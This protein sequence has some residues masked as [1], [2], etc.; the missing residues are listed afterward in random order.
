M[1][2]HTIV[3][4]GASRGIGNHAAVQMLRQAPD[5]H[6]PVTARGS[7]ED[8]AAQL[9]RDSGNPNVSWVTCELS[10]LSSIRSA[11]AEIGR[12]LETGALPPLTGF[13]GNAGVQMASANRTTPDD[14]ETTFAVN[15]LANHLF[16]RLLGDRLVQPARVVITTSDTHFGD[17][18]HNMGMVPAPQ[19]RAPRQLA[20]AGSSAATDTVT[21]GR[22]TYSTSKLAVIH[23]VHEF[24]RQLPAGVDIYSWNPGF[25]PGTGLAR[26]ANAVHRFAMRYVMPLMALTPLSVSA[27][28]A[29]R[30]LADV[31]LGDRLAD[32]G[33]YINLDEPESSSTES[34]DPARERELWQA[35]DELCRLT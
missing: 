23:L 12:R 13:V 4:T 6:L 35:A 22:T 8:L 3:M 21:A 24:S 33:A 10:S 2:H 15:V 29:G 16:L 1:Q 34:Y 7:G 17:F 30:R 27:K 11:A 20:R 19:W 14:L 5:L 9:V 32:S 25:V 26:D 28:T 18:R 31:V